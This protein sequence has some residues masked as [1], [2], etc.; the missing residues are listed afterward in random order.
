MHGS[1]YSFEHTLI[2]TKFLS[3]FRVICA[4]VNSLIPGSFTT[5]V[6]LNDRYVRRIACMYV[7]Y[8]YCVQY[9]QY[10]VNFSNSS[11]KCSLLPAC[12]PYG[13]CFL[14]HPWAL[15]WAF[16]WENDWLH[17]RGHACCRVSQEHYLH[18]KTW[19]ILQIHTMYCYCGLLH[20]SSVQCENNII[21]K[22]TSCV[23]S[24]ILPSSS[25]WVSALIYKYVRH[26]LFMV[27]LG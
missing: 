24:S 23:H 14:L 27:L 18:S 3:F 15:K 16:S 19:W 20:F 10:K 22:V 4:L 25:H 17:N 21:L 12:P 9:I 11:N 6:L 13:G 26:C 7:M 8:V 1:T 2:I 5:E